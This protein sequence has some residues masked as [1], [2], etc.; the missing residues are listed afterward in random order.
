MTLPPHFDQKSQ[1]VDTQTNIGHADKVI[2]QT[3]C[4]ASVLPIPHQIPPPPLDFTGRE[5]D[6]KGLLEQF[7]QGTTI[8][9]LRGMGGV[10][11]T[12]LALAFA[13]K[14]KD[15]FPDGQ[16]FLNMLG[17]SK[18]P[19]KP[20][21]VMAHIIRSYLGVDASLPEQLNG[22]SGLYRSVLSGK[23]A[24]ILLDNAA[25]R[26]QVESLL[27]PPFC[28]LLVTSRSKFALSGLAEK[29]LDVLPLEDAR[30]LLLEIAPRIGDHAEKLAML[31]GCLPIALRNAAYALKEKPNLSLE[32]YLE[33]LGDATKRL[34]LVDASFSTSYDLL[35]PELQ[36]LWSMLSVFPADF[37]LAGAAAVWE[38]KEMLAED[39]LGELIRWSLVDFLP[40]ATNEGGR[41]R[42]HDLARDFAESRL[43]EA[44]SE[45]A[46]L[47]HAEHY[48]VVLARAKEI[49]KQGKEATLK[50]L[51]LFDQERA[52]ILAGQS[53]AERNLEGT[54]A[55]IDL[56]KSYPNAG[57]YVLDLRLSPHEK[58]PWL[59]TAL[60]ASR[61]SYDRSAEEAHLGNLGLAYSN[62]GEPCKAIEFYEQALKITQEIGDRRGEGNHLGN[63][64]LDYSDLGEPRK[65][66]EFYE[67]A[68][69]ISRDIRDRRIEAMSLLAM[70]ISYHSLC[71]KDKAFSLAQ[72]ALEIFEQIE[73]PH[74][75]TVRQKLAEWSE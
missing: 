49:F 75:E 6:I 60:E 5:D 24:L 41:Y 48:I 53:W 29:D 10:G 59:E 28:A 37:D 33:R 65:A 63:L 72:S 69:K 58:I 50:G 30:K 57:V 22:L 15:R 14:L 43:D 56:C 62:L 55:V 42:L 74:A 16:L 64:G 7:G 52:N 25:S 66:I 34:E 46:K 35:T 3:S 23:K 51:Q 13:D 1:S 68:L 19:L 70:S 8:T 18:S 11:K 20:E 21:D 4:S 32:G 73:S 9:G 38:M 39:A 12:A 47:R 54:S 26:E 71:Q 36:R 61:K 44:D 27:P 2:I 17:T 45:T 67:Q 31:C 40:S